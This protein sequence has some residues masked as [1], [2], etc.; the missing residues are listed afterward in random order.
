VDYT[1][2]V[3]K[4]TSRVRATAWPASNVLQMLI[5]GEISKRGVIRQELDI[6]A[7]LFLNEMAVRGVGIGY[8]IET[9]QELCHE[10][11]ADVQV[12]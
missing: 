4:M 10:V 6:P 12:S 8:C 5:A 3:T 11:M 7:Q 1:D 2:S 9:K